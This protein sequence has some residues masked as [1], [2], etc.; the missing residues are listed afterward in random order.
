MLKGLFGSKQ[1]DTSLEIV[2]KLV[3]DK[4]KKAE[5]AHELIENENKSG[6]KFTRNARPAIVYTGLFIAICEV[7]GIR[8]LSLSWMD[9]DKQMV[10]S[11]TSMLQYIITTWSGVV[12]IYVGG[13]TYEKRKMKVFDKKK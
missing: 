12:G 1:I 10:D 2:D 4:D 6:S 5:M 8:L 9:A 3:T 7:F 13:R 11:S